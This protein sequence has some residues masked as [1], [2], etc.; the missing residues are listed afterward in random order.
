MVLLLLLACGRLLIEAIFI[1]ESDI[2][3]NDDV[4]C[5]ECIETKCKMILL[6]NPQ[7]TLT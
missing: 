5:C 4:I 7:C 2:V 1:I 3:Y 6:H